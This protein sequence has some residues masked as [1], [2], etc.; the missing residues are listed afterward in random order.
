MRNRYAM[1]ER[2]RSLVIKVDDD[3]LA[4]FH[5]L[6]NAGDEPISVMLRRWLAERY[7]A[8]FGDAKPARPKLKHAPKSRAA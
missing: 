7:T 8:K 4:R 6:A 2:D 3:E 5:A 1:R